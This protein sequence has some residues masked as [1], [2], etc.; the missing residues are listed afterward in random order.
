[1]TSSFPISCVLVLVLA[2]AGWPGGDDAVLAA[3]EGH[4]PPAL[5]DK[6]PPPDGPP[7]A[8]LKQVAG[9]HPRLLAS[10]GRLE[11]LR[12][13]Y[14]SPE[15][16]PYREQILRLLP[17]C[18]VPADRMTSHAW[19][20][21][22]GLQRMP[23]V[24]LHWLMTGDKHS[25]ERCVEYLT[26]L[27]GLPTWTTDGEGARD[28]VDSDTAAGF[29]MFGAAL[30]WD[31][32]YNDLEP[33][34]RER[35]RLD[36]WRHARAMYYGGHLGGNPGGFYWRGVPAYNHRWFRDGGLAMAAF[37]AAEGRPDEQ[38]LLGKVAAE[39]QFMVA[40]L[41]DDGSNHEGPNYGSAIGLL[42]MACQA[43]DECFGSH[44]LDAPHFRNLAQY[45]LD[46]AAPGGPELCFG[47]CWYHVPQRGGAS[48]FY[49]RTAAHF[50]QA[51]VIDGIRAALKA[52]SDDEDG[53]SALLCDDPT[54]TGGH[55]ARLPTAAFL[56]DLG[57]T[58]LRESW[59]DS[60]VTA[61]FKCGPLGGC[62]IQGWREQVAKGGGGLPYVNV[63]HEHPDANSFILLAD[64]EYLAETDRYCERPGKVS[65]SCNTI[66]VN[67]IGQVPK[68]RDEGDEWLQPGSDDMT[69]MG[70]IVAWKD[71]GEVVVAEG[72]AAGS[73]LAYA[74]AKQ[75]RE[76][77][78]LDRY[79]R[80]FIWVKGGY[81]L[82][83]DD[84]RAPQPVEIAW[85]VQGRKLAAVDAEHGRYR[86]SATKAECEFQLVAD[87]PFAAA[88]GV[89]T[90][91]DHSKPLGWQQL[92]ARA[93][94]TA[95]RFASVYDPWRRKDVQVALTAAGRDR[96]TVTVTVTTAGI[97]DTW[98]WQA[99]P[100]RFEAG[101]LHGK[102]AGGFDIVV[103]A[104]AVPPTAP[105][106]HRPAVR[107]D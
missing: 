71:A 12:A 7:V 85:L 93:T 52:G 77:P 35:F 99:T 32:T 34:F 96:A 8:F 82:V 74:D 4:A 2:L 29:T 87:A 9:K 68:G 42:G 10:P 44:H 41:P 1:M 31:W 84:I 39:L 62:K 46:L 72:E 53:W 40:W 11:Q 23:T 56:P 26:W 54:L 86:L 37:A 25:L 66:L 90:A 45:G 57:I 28:E 105:A 49:L 24:A 43:S 69:G 21:E 98:Q 89:S 79:R 27:D 55:Y 6:D 15:A 61:L 17:A 48:T 20:Q 18:V 100:G 97:K 88:I 59:R 3:G 5:P 107:K 103:D 73:Y 101:V 58:T 63:A 22:A 16:K 36:L 67:G 102:R 80:T 50:R 83:L 78:A 81:V 30:M 94:T 104:K 13:F 65:S 19:G 70:R 106:A 47:D 51:D 76:R 38:W 64:G 33:A 92:Q 60:A 91:N 95:I 14:A 75:H